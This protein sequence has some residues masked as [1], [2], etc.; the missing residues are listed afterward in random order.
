MKLNSFGRLG[1]APWLPWGR[2]HDLPAFL[3][4]Y[5]AG[6]WPDP[7]KPWR[8]ARYVVLD[9]ETS[10]LDERRDA[11]LAIGLV[12]IEDGRVRLDRRWHTM[13]R[14]P[15]G[16][17]VAASSIRIHG[18]MRNELSTAPTFDEILPA[19]I[20]RL[21]G[22]VLLVHVARIDVGF[23]NRALKP[24]GTKLRG[25]ILDTARIAITQHQRSQRLGEVSHD[26]PM[27]AI[28]LRGLAG[29]FGLPVYGQH[30]ALND[31]LT[32]AQVFLAQA[33]RMDQQGKHTL[34]AFL[35]SG[36]V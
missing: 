16:L 21:A 36:G 35:K 20:E 10:G 1:L 19:L 32:T 22:R 11:L 6:P 4:A 12:E 5:E 3:R 31:A 33:A 15:E 28:Q 7:H 13:I 17:L 18:L 8:E 30:D 14:P 27:P 2:K 34:K 24:Y 25:P 29:S 26:M 23:L 9:V